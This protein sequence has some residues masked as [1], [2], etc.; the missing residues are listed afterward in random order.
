MLADEHKHSLIEPEDFQKKIG[1][2][3]KTEPSPPP[4]VLGEDGVDLDLVL[5]TTALS[6]VQRA[7]QSTD[8]RK[9]EA[10]KLLGLNDRFALRRRVKQIADAYPDL[11][12]RFPVVQDLYRDQ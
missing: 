7:L 10:W 3:E 4:V 11:M 5:A 6:Y 8:R 12:R 2:E 9:T 1:P